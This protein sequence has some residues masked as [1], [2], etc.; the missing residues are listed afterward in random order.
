ML[1]QRGLELTE[2]DIHRIEENKR[3]LE[4]IR[5][6]VKEKKPDTFYDPIND[7]RK[8]ELI[9]YITKKKRLYTETEL[10]K[11]PFE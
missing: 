6:Q 9:D 5:N 1:S 2:E 4:R 7:D 10:S 11:L 3:E 8:K